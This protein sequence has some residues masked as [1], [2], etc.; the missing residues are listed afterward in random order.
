MT[1]FTTTPLEGASRPIHW[2]PLRRRLGV[3]RVLLVLATV[4]ITSRL[5][6]VQVLDASRYKNAGVGEITQN[7]PI[8]A[9]RGGIYDRNGLVLALSQQT[10]MVIA[11]DFQISHPNKE[12]AALAPLLGK[13]KAT[14]VAALSQSSGYV[15]LAHYLS[16]A[17]ASR[18]SALN[19]PGITLASD[20]RRVEPNGTLASPV[21]GG[22]NANGTGT[23]GLEYQFDH[24]LSGK[25]GEKSVLESPTGVQLPGTLAR[26]TSRPTA[27]TGLELTL[28]TPLQY[29]VESD[30]A[31]EIAATKSVSGEAIVED[32]ATG[33]ILAMANL[34]ANEKKANLIP[35]NDWVSSPTPVEVGTTGVVD[36]AP[37]NFCL[38]QLYEPGS[39]FKLVTFSAALSAGVITPNSTFS[40]PGH[41]KV[42]GSTFHDS[43]THPTET[44]SADQILSQ[45]SNI[46]TAEIAQSLGET[47]ILA[48]V[49]RLGFGSNDGFIFPGESQGL[50]ITKK[51][52]EPTDIVS[53]PIGQ[54]D[55]VNALQ[56]L[57][58]Y[59]AVANGGVYVDPSLVRATI[60]AGNSVRAVAKSPSHRALSQSV[61]HEL[62]TMLEHVVTSPTATGVEAAVTGYAVAGKTGTAQIPTVG[63]NSY[64][65]GAYMASFV[66]F[67]PAAHPVLSAIVVLNHSD[68]IYGGSTA[69]PVFSKIMAYALHRYDVPT[70]ASAPK[71]LPATSS[72]LAANKQDVT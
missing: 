53:L 6:Q 34:V 52:W 51:T 57:S 15:A 19:L 21:L 7:Q 59:N 35:A 17:K 23:G 42:D 63:A 1:L 70:T 26:I 5:V 8:T 65:N 12:A 72:N 14:L 60:G 66:G 68:P 16:P 9:V 54:V 47:K 28:D 39:V 3:V 69:A 13:S 44:L 41:L 10:K 11:D 20:E 67:A 36:Q 49:H 43:E 18:I 40:V 30:L 61:S 46:G 29:S 24:L 27:G 55:A 25:D 37:S 2:A 4:L 50:L 33:Q 64:V 22:V 58:A 38:T 62:T 48:Q 56:V 45:S 71:V 32:V 31:A